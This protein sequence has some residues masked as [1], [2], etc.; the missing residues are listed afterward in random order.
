MSE[1]FYQSFLNQLKL[2]DSNF[3]WERELDGNGEWTGTYCWGLKNII[4]CGKGRFR[5]FKEVVNNISQH[6]QIQP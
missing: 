3:Y 4:H 1:E 5:T 6:I 2:I